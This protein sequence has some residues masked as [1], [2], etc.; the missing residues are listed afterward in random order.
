MPPPS[1][2]TIA[3]LHPI[4]AGAEVVETPSLG[5]A[6]V[7]EHP[8]TELPARDIN[9][10][11]RELDV[12]HDSL[13]VSHDIQ[14]T[15]IILVDNH[16]TVI[17]NENA[18]SASI[19][20]AAAQLDPDDEEEEGRLIGVEVWDAV[21]SPGK[22]TVKTVGVEE[23][24]LDENA[25]ID[26][27]NGDTSLERP[28]ID[29]VQAS[30]DRINQPSDQES[31]IWAMIAALTVWC[32]FFASLVAAIWSLAYSMNWEGMEVFTA[33]AVPL[34][35]K[36]LLEFFRVP[37]TFSLKQA[38]GVDFAAA[39]IVAPAFIAFAN[40]VWFKAAR[41]LSP[42]K[43]DAT[44]VDMKMDLM[45]EEAGTYD[46]S[47]LVTLLRTSKPGLILFAILLLSS[48]VASTLLSN[49]LGYQAI[50]PKTSDIHRTS[51]E[52]MYQ[53]VY[54]PGLL[55]LALCAIASASSSSL[56]L[57]ILEKRSALLEKTQ[58]SQDFEC[59]NRIVT[60]EH[61]ECDAADGRAH[62]YVSFPRF[63]TGRRLFSRGGL[64]V[65]RLSRRGTSGEG[66]M[67]PL[68]RR[69]KSQVST[70]TPT[71]LWMLHAFGSPSFAFNK[72]TDSNASPDASREQVDMTRSTTQVE[73]QDLSSK[74]SSWGSLQI[75]LSEWCR[76][77]ATSQNTEDQQSQETTTMPPS[78]IPTMVRSLKKPS[79][80]KLP[81]YGILP[82]QHDSRVTSVAS[83]E[84]DPLTSSSRSPDSEESGPEV[85]S[86]QLLRP[87]WEISTVRG[88]LWPKG[89][90]RSERRKRQLEGV[91]ETS[92][93]LSQVEREDVGLPPA[94]RT[95]SFWTVPSFMGHYT[96]P[97][98]RVLSPERQMIETAVMATSTDNTNIYSTSRNSWWLPRSSFWS[99]ARK[100]A[101]DV[102]D[103]GAATAALIS[104]LERIPGIQSEVVEG[105][106]KAIS[107]N[108]S[109][110]HRQQYSLS[111]ISWF[112][113]FTFPLVLVD[114]PPRG[115]KRPNL[116]PAFEQE[117]ATNSLASSSRTLTAS[118]GYNMMTETMTYTERNAPSSSTSQFVQDAG[119]VDKSELTNQIDDDSPVK[120]AIPLPSI[121]WSMPRMQLPLFSSGEY[122]SLAG[123]T[124]TE[125]S[126]DTQSIHS[127]SKSPPLPQ[128]L[129]PSPLMIRSPSAKG[130]EIEQHVDQFESPNFHEAETPVVIREESVLM[131]G[132][133]IDEEDAQS[134]HQKTDLGIGW[135]PRSSRRIKPHN[136]EAMKPADRSPSSTGE[137]RAS[138]KGWTWWDLT[139]PHLVEV[140]HSRPPSTTATS[141]Q[142]SE[143]STM[144]TDGSTSHDLEAQ[145]ISSGSSMGLPTCAGSSGSYS[146]K[147]PL[148]SLGKALMPLPQP[149]PIMHPGCLSPSPIITGNMP[150]ILGH[151]TSEQKPG[152]PSSRISR[153]GRT[154]LLL[155]SSKTPEGVVDEERKNASP[156][157]TEWPWDCDHHFKAEDHDSTPFWI[158][159]SEGNG[160]SR[161]RSTWGF[162]HRT[163]R[164]NESE[165]SLK[166]RC[167]KMDT[168]PL[169]EIQ[170]YLG[171]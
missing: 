90:W 53:I 147:Q 96:A 69:T 74:K 152:E 16:V 114:V 164:S 134:A 166:V 23:T 78:I 129:A 20:L 89:G 65:F 98:S 51:D 70:H 42:R 37:Q 110:S 52:L 162:N 36:A 54:I 102:N 140:D 131:Q 45:N 48:A 112:P 66:E 31:S 121:R 133:D 144:S 80:W 113:A 88:C 168:E 92:S 30:Q 15:D 38:K 118:E 60:D 84:H 157:A 107:S 28:T 95:P 9:L 14:E 27:E 148:W 82:L 167:V 19:Q 8:A 170:G 47:K 56:L 154:Q 123:V 153:S 43:P 44:N 75:R 35:P 11:H 24:I 109:K 115:D 67:E 91:S 105:P 169:V 149:S 17:D 33:I 155:E 93:L 124:Q 146:R 119:R 122:E 141:R 40:F 63:R 29:A 86:L 3:G 128:P 13:L 132:T 57:I 49:V 103:R 77:R 106:V 59:A 116:L 130:K 163:R 12:Q 68:L 151:V 34:P 64:E 150:E 26:D 6:I 100:S 138:W 111:S 46:L 1:A 71:V 39:A 135:A 55:L 171:F 4:I 97:A 99:R 125:T 50:P 2:E 101:G 104:R 139:W 81:N 143:S 165:T 18:A 62:N 79:F 145:R 117:A 156:I 7:H 94:Q 21:D 158:G 85:S 58:S 160:S 25:I 72:V 87:C 126:D 73:Q 108:H 32:C 137:D 161:V 159:E 127:K 76:L 83:I 22:H 136:I 5:P 61:G 120:R 41:R 10:N 142:V